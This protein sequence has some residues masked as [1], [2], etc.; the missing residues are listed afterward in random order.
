MLGPASAR[1]HLRGGGNACSRC[2]CLCYQAAGDHCSVTTATV[3]KW[4]PEPS[5]HRL[6][7]T[8][9][10]AQKELCIPDPISFLVWLQPANLVKEQI[11]RAIWEPCAEPGHK[12]SE[13]ALLWVAAVAQVGEL[14]A[15]VGE[16]LACARRRWRYSPALWVL[17]QLASPSFSWKCYLLFD[18]M[19]FWVFLFVK[20][21]IFFCASPF[22]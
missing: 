3:T 21:G 15:P 1:G 10:D 9:R 13:G 6:L 4:Q 22:K 17:T 2:C 18:T 11:V 5:S 19:I 14:R 20:G 7:N 8:L 12:G 16:E